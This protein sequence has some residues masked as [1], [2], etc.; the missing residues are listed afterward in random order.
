M[1]RLRALFA[2]DWDATVQRFLDWS[3]ERLAF[4]VGAVIVGLTVVAVAAEIA[5][6]VS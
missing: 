4:G 5:R 6:R 3:W 1:R 2:A